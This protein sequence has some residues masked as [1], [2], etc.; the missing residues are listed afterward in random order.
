MQPLTK[1]RA[2]IEIITLT[3]FAA[4]LR[5]YDLEKRV[6]HHDEAAVGHFTYQ[7]FTNGVYSYNPAF[8]GPFLYYATSPIY[9]LLGDTIFSSR[10]L[11]A[12]FGVLMVPLVFALRDRIGRRGAIIAAFFLA[13]SPSFL[14]YSRFFRNDIFVTFCMLAAIIC[15]LKYHDTR[16]LFCTA[17]AGMFLGLSAAAK[18]NTY[19][20]I[21]IFASYL[22][23]TCL[24]DILSRNL[25]NHPTKKSRQPLKSIKKQYKGIITIL[26]SFLVVYALFYTDFFSNP[27]QFTSSFESAVT[28]WYNMHTT[29][30]ISG[31]PY[32][33]IPI[34]LL[35]ELP[36]VIFA[37]I[38][39][40]Q[41]VKKPDRFKTFLIYW[42]LT[43][44]VAYSYL[45][46][47]VPWL[48][49]HILLP[50][51]L[52]ASTTLNETLQ[53]IILKNPQL[54]KGTNQN[55]LQT[56]QN[57]TPRTKQ[58]LL[59]IFIITTLLLI[60]TS[61]HLNYHNYTTPAE[62]LIQA[63]QPPQKFQEMLD[64]ID[65]VANQWNGHETRI[66]VTDTAIE[67]QFL[68]YLRHYENIQWKVNLNS[69]LDTPLIV[70]HNTDTPKIQNKLDKQYQQLDSA[71]MNW[72]W[73]KTSDITIEY[74]LWREL[75]RPPDEYGITLFY[76]YPT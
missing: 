75:K 9:S 63:A 3:L 72:Y 55:S 46:E 57:N 1:H 62:P 36:I 48:T 30:R 13:I 32:F 70:V 66:Q 10:L 35:Y 25:K 12:I 5:L 42:T 38:G 20:Y 56:Q 6:F 45:G 23:F 16:N 68:W 60:F 73:L 50:M 19:I 8:H 64:K 27:Q 24:Q 34:L 51:I 41:P 4:I 2:Q 61:L 52:L 26:T 76:K 74:I 18:E 22:I 65:E 28:H 37:A 53:R 40:L 15:I 33:Y 7:L 17:G 44:L 29:K 21:A 71:K 31:P 11:P 67:T 58:I 59:M 69:T 14:Y 49:I 43:S 54:E 39:A 47:K